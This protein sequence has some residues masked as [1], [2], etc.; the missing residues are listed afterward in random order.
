MLTK[1]TLAAA[2]LLT[3][4]ATA[5]ARSDGPGNGGSTNTVWTNGLTGN[6]LGSNG[7][8]PSGLGANSR[9]GASA[10]LDQLNSVRVETVVLP[11]RSR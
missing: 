9:T 8:Q 11:D 10:A 4:G 5:Q 7:V 6:G 2:V 3:A 1:I